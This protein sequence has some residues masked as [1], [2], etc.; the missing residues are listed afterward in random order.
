ME[1]SLR[2][3][4]LEPFQ[5]PPATYFFSGNFAGYSPLKG[6]YQIDVYRV[7]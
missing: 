1:L 2:E 4:Y 3:F 7:F 5:L 6:G